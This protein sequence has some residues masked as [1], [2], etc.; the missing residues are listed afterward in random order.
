FL[1]CEA[2]HL[3]AEPAACQLPDKNLVGVGFYHSCRPQAVIW[4]QQVSG[5]GLIG[6]ELK[7]PDRC[8]LVAICAP[9]AKFVEHNRSGEEISTM[10]SNTLGE[11]EIEGE[12]PDDPMVSKLINPFIIPASLWNKPTNERVQVGALID[13]GCI[14]T[15]IWSRHVPG[16]GLI[17]HKAQASRS[18]LPC[19]LAV[20]C[21]PMAKLV[22]RGFRVWDFDCSEAFEDQGF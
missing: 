19:F 4:S 15:V 11:D 13:S 18:R 12:I 3:H 1:I 2:R 20:I 8:F 6:G 14:R 9:M 7:L 10:P 16:G 5:G 17:G 22:E 21:V